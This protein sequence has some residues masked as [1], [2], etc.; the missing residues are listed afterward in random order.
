[1]KEK[2]FTPSFIEQQVGLTDFQKNL[3]WVLRNYYNDNKQTE[4][5]T[6]EEILEKI[7]TAFPKENIT[8]KPS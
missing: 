2:S 6:N 3:F 4:D 8:I 5:T 1:M 7:K